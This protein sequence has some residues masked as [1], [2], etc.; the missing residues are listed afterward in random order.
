MFQTNLTC[1]LWDLVDEGIEDVLDRLK[2]E[3]GIRGIT[4]P[5]VCRPIQQFRPHAG[6]LPR[7]FRSPGGAQFQPAA[8]LYAGT[9][10]RPVTAAWLRARNPLAQVAQA[11]AKRGMNLRVSIDACYQPA[12][13][14]RHPGCAP[15]NAFGEGISG[16]LCPVNPE[17]RDHLRALAEDL[18]QNYAVAALEVDWLGFPD[19][20]WLW[21]C[22]T[23]PDWL[24]SLCLCDSCRQL[25]TRQGVDAA[26]AAKVVQELLEQVLANGVSGATAGTVEALLAEEPALAAYADWGVSQV[27]SLA[28]GLRKSCRCRLVI[29]RRWPDRL[30]AGTDYPAIARHCDA[31]LAEA[32]PGNAEAIETTVKQLAREAG[33]VSRVELRIAVLMGDCPDSASLV[34]LVSQAARMGVAGAELRNY[35]L[36]PLARLAWIKQAARFAQRE[37]T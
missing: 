7:V 27:T 22:G 2:G 21:E 20:G 19:T 35:G 17:V 15:R 30:D 11:C 24:A 31:L 1:Y 6:V 5:A 37:S 32:S 36:L 33:D 14:E 10:L 29:A 9:R 13:A 16:W 26:A 4:V 12:L 18:T 8:A 25:A 34:R 23:V 28:E 3:A